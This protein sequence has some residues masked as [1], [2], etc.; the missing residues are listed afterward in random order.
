MFDKKITGFQNEIEFFN[1]LNNKKIKDINYLFRLFLEDL[2]GELN[3]NYYVECRVNFEK[4]KYDIVIKINSIEKKV[5]LKKGIKN[6][7]HVEGISNFI[8]FLIE[9]KIDKQN[10]VNYLKYHYADGTTNGTGLERL[11]S[12]EYKKEHQFEIDEINIALNKEK[13]LTRAVER[14]I[15]T[16]NISNNSI[17]AM[18]YGVVDDFIWIK[19]EDIINLVLLKK[20][21]Y[22]T[23]VHF[24]PLTIQ[25]L[26]RCLN[27]NVKYENRRFCIQVKWYNIFDDVLEY[28]NTIMMQGSGYKNEPESSKAVY[29]S[30]I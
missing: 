22:S 10:V 17:D 19:K 30:R 23:A 3:E 6:S 2:Y 29:G 20:D 15:L 21:V 18:I 27:K 8:H 26:D 5:S 14:F 4:Q 11:S 28:K 16:G 7:V 13:I 9:N 12:E 25:P 24:G 1:K